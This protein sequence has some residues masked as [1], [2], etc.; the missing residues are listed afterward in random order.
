RGDS[1]PSYKAPL[2]EY[3][4]IMNEVLDAGELPALPGFEDATPDLIASV[5]EEAAKL[6][7]TVLQPLNQRGDAE[8]CTYENGTVRTPT[9]FKE[10]YDKYVEGGWP[11]LVGL[12][13]P[14]RA[15]LRHRSRAYQ[16]PCRTRRR[17]HLQNHGHENLHY[18]GRARPH[19]QYRP[20]CARETAGCAG[21]HQGHLTLPR[22]QIHSGREWR[23]RPPQRRALR[24]YR[25][26]DGDQGIRDLRDEFRRCGWL[27]H[28]R[29]EPR[30]AGDV[31]DDERGAARRRHSGSWRCRSGEAKCAHL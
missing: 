28:R 17:W 26:Q 20:S 3:R 30:H 21:R 13:V 5:L 10:A 14:D 8:G 7:E 31:H 18:R 23:A 24:L 6:C 19:A 1:M 22:A 2:D 27:A 11:G 25:A 29:A 4:F 12:H 16:D 15:S 9:G